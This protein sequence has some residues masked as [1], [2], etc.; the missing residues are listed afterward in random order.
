M[1]TNF[2]SNLRKAS[3]SVMSGEVVMI[4]RSLFDAL[5]ESAEMLYAKTEHDQ[6]CRIYDDRAC[7]CHR[8]RLKMRLDALIRP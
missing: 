7:D 5:I 6:H 1:E 2:S 3:E 4:D 8:G